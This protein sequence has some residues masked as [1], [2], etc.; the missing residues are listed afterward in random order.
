MKRTTSARQHSQGGQIAMTTL[1][2]GAGEAAIAYLYHDAPNA[3]GDDYICRIR[4]DPQSEAGLFLT[5]N[6][7]LSFID[8]AY[9]PTVVVPSVEPR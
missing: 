6:W 1:Q 8:Q 5:M 7:C 9:R 2:Y 4:I 3:E